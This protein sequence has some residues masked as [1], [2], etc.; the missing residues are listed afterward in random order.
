MT[1]T[2][3]GLAVVVDAT[4]TAVAL[5]AVAKNLR[6]WMFMVNLACCWAR[7]CWTC[8]ILEVLS[9]AELAKDDIEHLC[10]DERLIAKNPRL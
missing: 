7:S 10:V 4:E 5:A 9:A 8:A 6:R 1:S 2:P 3:V